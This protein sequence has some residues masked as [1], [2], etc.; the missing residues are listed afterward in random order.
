[1]R[2]VRVCRELDILALLGFLEEHS[3]DPGPQ[4][5]EDRHTEFRIVQFLADSGSPHTVRHIDQRKST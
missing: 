2:A 1:M 3:L 5:L 4:K